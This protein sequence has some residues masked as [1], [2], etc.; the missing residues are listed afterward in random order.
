MSIAHSVHFLYGFEGDNCKDFKAVF[1]NRAMVQFLIFLNMKE[2]RHK[3]DFLMLFYN[4][5]ADICAQYETCMLIFW[6]FK[7]MFYFDVMYFSDTSNSKILKNENVPRGLTTPFFAHSLLFTSTT[8]Y[9]K[10]VIQI[11]CAHS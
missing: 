2:R 4:T 10:H 11:P 7:K 8:T 1:C 9:V 6:L 3:S 5:F